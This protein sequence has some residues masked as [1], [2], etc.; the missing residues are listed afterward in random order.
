[1]A[2]APTIRFPTELLD[3]IRAKVP[4][5]K[6]A[7]KLVALKKAGREFR[8]L[9]PFKDEKTPSFF[10]NDAKG[11]YHCFASRNHGDVFKFLMDTE[12][13]SMGEAVARLAKE[14]GV[15][16]KSKKATPEDSNPLWPHNGVRL[17]ISH[18][19]T[20]K[21]LAHDIKMAVG[22]CDCFICGS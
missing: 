14:A 19:D 13:V 20:N 12:G 2:K 16:L 9:S 3:E 6:V 18:R 8:G 22:V 4:I 11:F 5:S 17:F 21:V 7:G 10:V 15:S 1:M